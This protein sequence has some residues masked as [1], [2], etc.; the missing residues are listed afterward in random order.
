MRINMK[1]RNG[2]VSNSSSSSF[3]IAFKKN[4]C[5]SVF[6]KF[7]NWKGYDR[8]I[9]DYSLAK[10]DKGRME[11]FLQI[12]VQKVCYFI[13][14]YLLA[15]KKFEDWETIKE[16]T[17]CGKYLELHYGISDDVEKIVNKHTIKEEHYSHL[18]KDGYKKLRELIE[19][20]HSEVMKIVKKTYKSFTV[21]EYSDNN[22]LFDAYM[23]H[24]FMPFMLN[25]PMS[26][27]DE[28]HNLMTISNH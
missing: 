3:V 6:N 4:N 15:G 11:H 24:D 9:K 13:A 18:D 22:S 20:T 19:K 7:S 17:F 21:L 8:F 28:N 10:N 16:N 5:D 27:N 26:I 25:N 2:Y 1:I 12:D 23:E 14:E